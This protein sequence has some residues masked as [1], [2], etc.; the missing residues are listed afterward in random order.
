MSHTRQSPSVCFVARLDFTTKPGG[1]TVQWQMYDRV[2]REAG[3]RTVT[4]FGDEPRPEA[5]VYHAFNIDRPL[6]L[7][8]KLRAVRR[9]GRPYLLSTIH[10]PNGWLEKFRTRHPPGGRLGRWLYRSPLGRSIPATEAVKEVARLLQQR[11]LACLADLFPGWSSRVCWLLKNAAGIT[12]LSPAEAGFIESDFGYSGPGGQSVVLPNWV[13]GIAGTEGEVPVAQLEQAR[14]AILVVGRI[15]A[16]KNTVGVA[17]LL[18]QAGEKA[19]FVGRPNPNEPEYEADFKAATGSAQFVRWIPGVPRSTLAAF[20]RE[21]RMLLNASYVEVSPLVDIEALACGCPVITTRHALHHAL[22]P[23]GTPVVD[24]YDGDNVLAAVK[25]VVARDVARE[26]IDPARC[27]AT[28][29]GL[30]ASVHGA[31]S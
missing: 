17:R 24:P 15:E 5:D 3:W 31:A 8:P 30:Y 1:D 18:E 14:D 10:H 20:Y 21:G 11:R 9:A 6:E 22:L 7:Y 23:A 25:S 27:K 26:V 4:W 2:A 16:R 19:L 12:L 29:L 28:L 13:E